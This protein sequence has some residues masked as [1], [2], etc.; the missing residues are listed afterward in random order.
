MFSIGNVMK[1]RKTLAMGLL[2]MLTVIGYNIMRGMKKAIML[3]LPSAGAAYIPF[4]KT[5]LVMPLS[6]IIGALY[7]IIRHRHG[8]VTAYHT[9]T[10]AFLAYFILFT[11]VLLPGIAHVTPDP[12]W[13]A[14]IQHNYPH[15]KFLVGLLSNW[16][17]AIYY[18][19]AE[20][21]GTYSLVVL[22]WQIANELY[23]PQEATDTYPFFIFVSSISIIIASYALQLLSA[24]ESPLVS[25]TITMSLL[26]AGMITIVNSLSAQ[27][28]FSQTRHA[29]STPKKKK[30]SLADSVRLTLTSPH[31]LYIGVCVFSFGMLV[32]FF[33]LSLDHK[34]A[35]YYSDTKLLLEFQSWFTR[36]KGLLCIAANFINAMLLRRIGWFGV[37]MIT[38]CICILSANL[39]L[40]SAYH[41]DLIQQVL[42]LSSAEEL[43]LLTGCILLVITYACKYSFFDTTKELAFTPL[44]DSV[45]A[46]A[47]AV[48]DGI[49]GRAG[50]SGSS[51]VQASLITMTAAQSIPDI[52]PYLLYFGV[53]LSVFWL[54]SMTRLNNSYIEKMQALGPGQDQAATQQASTVSEP[55]QQ[56]TAAST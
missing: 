5:M 1:Q 44:P 30:I 22:F 12:T 16:P 20:L 37:A 32:N 19:A 21:W 51:F 14:S 2:V 17:I 54:W 31:V 9:I 45:K 55:T 42:Q 4:V 33:E 36:T 11:F 46:S 38:P 3:S 49:C 41:V 56:P 48:A 52:I 50:K 25:C 27:H 7:L 35:E 26:S 29:D 23:S 18:V 13:I 24:S 8:I 10:L 47:K 40:F 15:F 39:F 43:I 6:I 34:L 28:D 53:F